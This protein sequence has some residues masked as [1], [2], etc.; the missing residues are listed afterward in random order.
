MNQILSTS[1]P[2]DNKKKKEKKVNTNPVAI[3]S[4]LKFFA[5]AMLIFGIFTIGTG[6]YAVFKNQSE[7]QEQNLEPSISIE[8]K[9]EETILLKVVHKK[10]IAK[11]EYRWNDEESTVVNGNNGKYIEK[12]IKVPSGKNTLHVLVVD[13][14]GKEI[15]Y[16]K[17]YER[18][19][20]INFEVSGNK[21][22]ITYEGD[23]KVSYM[24]YRWDEEEEK[25]IQINDTKIDQEIDAIKGLHTLT[26]IVVDEDNNTDTKVQKINGVSKPKI[27][28]AVDDAKQHF[29]IKAS[30]DEKITTIVFRLN[31]D[32]NQYYTLNIADMNYNDIQ[33]VLPMELQSGENTI[34]VTIKNASGVTEES[35][36]IKYQK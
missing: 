28:V 8:D 26:V 22:K 15:P 11:L 1:M 23:K 27:T 17:Q 36:I 34:E 21:I 31:Q 33:Y 3:K 6:V 4:I 30:D 25:T 7:Q 12:Q 16:E 2:M 32:D 18:E 9:D 14:D 20:K 5:I 10:N 13:E 24:T 29:V 35:G 19:S